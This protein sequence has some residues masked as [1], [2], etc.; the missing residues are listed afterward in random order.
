[1]PNYKDRDNRIHFLDDAKF[2]HLLPVGSV[3]I[4][5]AEAAILQAPTA[6]QIAESLKA[7]K[8]DEFN[9]KITVDTVDFSLNDDS[10]ALYAEAG[11]YFQVDNTTTIPFF[12]AIGQTVTLD[13]T[14]WKKIVNK[15]KAKRLAFF[16]T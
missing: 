14:M 9:K 5:D 1:M 11:L 16:A 10:R 6:E 13:Y 8:K 7:L 12:P 4:T 15:M 2:E 3:P